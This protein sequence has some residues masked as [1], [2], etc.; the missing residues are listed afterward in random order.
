VPKALK[1][2]GLAAIFVAGALLAGVASGGRSAD[3]TTT[4]TTTTAVT[5]TTESTST[6]TT[7]ATETTT[8]TPTQTTT[9]IVTVPVTT[10]PETSNSTPAWVWALIAVLAVGLIALI[11]VLARRGS[12]T[13]STEER[14]RQ[15]DAAVGSWAAQGWGVESETGDSAVLRR[16][17][18][19]MLVSVDSA[20]HVSTRPLPPS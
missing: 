12:H 1:L 7:A 5:T 6:E 20:G 13:V 15:L 2:S 16:G 19:S 17:A 4:E 10:A 3:S 9:Q 11:V 18:E 14:R 8:T